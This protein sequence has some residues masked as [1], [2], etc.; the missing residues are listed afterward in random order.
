[1]ALAVGAINQSGNIQHRHRDLATVE[2]VANVGKEWT[3]VA[4]FVSAPSAP[5]RPASS[6]PDW[7]H[8]VQ[9]YSGSQER[10][11]YPLWVY[12]D[13]FIRSRRL[14]NFLRLGTAA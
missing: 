11:G 4:K 5:S 9:H 3:G 2:T 8:C 12:V 10:P 7:P 1:M 6:R 14:R 13:F